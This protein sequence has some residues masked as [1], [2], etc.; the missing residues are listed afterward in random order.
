MQGSPQ[1]D[2]LQFFNNENFYIQTQEKYSKF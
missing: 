1:I 2:F